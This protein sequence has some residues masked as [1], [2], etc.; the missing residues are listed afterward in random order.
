MSVLVVA[1][2]LCR[3]IIRIQLYLQR[4]GSLDQIVPAVQLKSTHPALEPV[5]R[6]FPL[7][8]CSAGGLVPVLPGIRVLD[9]RMAA[10]HLVD[11]PPHILA[12]RALVR[13]RLLGGRIDRRRHLRELLDDLS[14]ARIGQAPRQPLIVLPCPPQQLLVPGL[15]LSDRFVNDRADELLRLLATP[16]PNP[17][18]GFGARC[19][20]TRS[21]SKT[22]FLNAA[23]LALV[24]ATPR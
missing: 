20:N 2:L 22:I 21:V 19:V 18:R 4:Y 15:R 5:G 8:I 17:F 9:H 11:R 3:R 12:G 24:D 16:V 7:D 6:A 10:M 13:R 23:S 14:S 1:Y